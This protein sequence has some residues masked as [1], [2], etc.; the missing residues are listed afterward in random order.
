MGR[1]RE[2]RRGGVIG[3]D[4]AVGNGAE[5]DGIGERLAYNVCSPLG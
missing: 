1:E 3:R 4:G 5:E 2:K